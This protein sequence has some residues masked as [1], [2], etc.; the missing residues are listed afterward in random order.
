MGIYREIADSVASEGRV[1]RREDGCWEDY[2][3]TEGMVM[4]DE[5]R[6][7]VGRMRGC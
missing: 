2:G 4:V 5:G 3:D 6:T 1:E 7:R